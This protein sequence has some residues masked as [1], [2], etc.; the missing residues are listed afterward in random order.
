[1]SAYAKLQKELPASPKTWLVT[2]A[3]GFIGSNLV[4][5]LLKLDQR[6]VGLD[7]FATGHRKNFTHVEK[8]VQPAQWARFQLIE[9]DLAD[10]DACSRACGG[11]DLILH[12][13]ALGSVPRSIADP[14]TTHR[15]N[16]DGFINIL[17]AACNAKVKRFVYASSSSVYGDHPDLPKVEEKTGNPLSPYAAT[18]VI[19]E[20]YAGVYAR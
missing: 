5:T 7:N 17:S 8:A 16:V 6:V 20:I 1:M 19:N 13:G 12:Q 2:G 11:V 10:R 3:A 4:E 14:I 15:A 9:G 18:K